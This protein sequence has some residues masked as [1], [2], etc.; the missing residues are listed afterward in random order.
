MD[1]YLSSKTWLEPQ[2]LLGHHPNHKGGLKLLNEQRP[3]EWGWKGKAW[4]FFIAGRYLGFVV[5]SGVRSESPGYEAVYQWSYR[6]E[7][8]PCPKPVRP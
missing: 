1:M 8:M 6:T 4:L 7:D 3:E 2:K 5:W